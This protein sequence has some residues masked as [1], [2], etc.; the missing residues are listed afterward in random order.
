M[1]SSFNSNSCYTNDK[2]CILLISVVLLFGSK[3][4]GGGGGG[5]GGIMPGSVP[6]P[7]HS[8]QGCSTV[9]TVSGENAQYAKTP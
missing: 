4:R 9:I 3:M 5:G 2:K 6:S 8:G 7:G 1:I